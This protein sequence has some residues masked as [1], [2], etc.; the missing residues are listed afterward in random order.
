MKIEDLEINVF[1]GKMEIKHP[2]LARTRVAD[3]PK[4]KTAAIQFAKKVAGNLV[5]FKLISLPIDKVEELL[6]K[7]CLP[8]EESK[9][10]TDMVDV[11]QPFETTVPPTSPAP[12]LTSEAAPQIEKTVE[13]PK[14]EEKALPDWMDGLSDEQ[15]SWIKKI[16]SINN[17]QEKE[18]IESLTKRA[19][20]SPLPT[21]PINVL[22]QDAW[23]HDLVTISREKRRFVVFAILTNNQ[24]EP[25]GELKFLVPSSVQIELGSCYSIADQPYK[26]RC[27][28]LTPPISSKHYEGWNLPTYSKLE[29]IADIGSI[30]EPLGC[31]QPIYLVEALNRAKKDIKGLHECVTGTVEEARNPREDLYYLEINDGTLDK[32]V[33]VSVGPLFAD[34]PWGIT[35]KDIKESKGKTILVYGFMIYEPPSKDW[36][37]ERLTI[38]PAFIAFA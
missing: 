28:A 5:K 4:D 22:Y 2:K 11:F 33:V 24:D 6:I 8:E 34:N 15:R 29:K 27:I 30:P 36:Y 9:Q 10:E 19:E 1:E 7:L 23:K 26:G 35:E 17:M 18:Y 37:R 21:H 3:I 14:V 16:A 32:S 12:T 31:Y 13:V 25:I 20:S 38:N